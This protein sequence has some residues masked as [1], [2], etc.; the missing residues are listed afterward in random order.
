MQKHTG[1]IMQK[2]IVMHSLLMIINTRSIVKVDLGEGYLLWLITKRKVSI[3]LQIMFVKRWLF[4]MS[5]GVY[6]YEKECCKELDLDTLWSFGV[7]IEY[8]SAFWIYGNA[9]WCLYVDRTKIKSNV[10]WLHVEKGLGIL[11]LQHLRLLCCY[12]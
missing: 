1:D 6:M 8:S 4:N 2:H 12:L 7:N 9:H 5:K 10:R 3:V 11:D